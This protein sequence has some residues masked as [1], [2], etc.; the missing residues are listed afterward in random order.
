[1]AAYLEQSILLNSNNNISNVLSITT[2]KGRSLY[3]VWLQNLLIRTIKRELPKGCCV[4]YPFKNLDISASTSTSAVYNIIDTY[5]LSVVKIRSG[6][7]YSATLCVTSKR[8]RSF[9]RLVSW[10]KYNHNKIKIIN[11]T[12]LY[13]LVKR[14]FYCHVLFLLYITL[15]KEQNVFRRRETI[16]K[17]ANFTPFIALAPSFKNKLQI[18]S[19]YIH[20]NIHTHLYICVY[21]GRIHKLSK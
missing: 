4:C 14:F 12:V 6:H 17:D 18:L 19:A 9:T 13:N 15:Y 11:T 21:C 16:R 20:T 8:K 1:M 2:V 10:N 7:F 3:R 5:I